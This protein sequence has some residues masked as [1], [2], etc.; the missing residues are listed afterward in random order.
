MADFDTPASKVRIE[1]TPGQV[2]RRVDERDIAEMLH[3][4]LGKLLGK[5][6]LRR[7]GEGKT[8]DETVDEAIQGA[9]KKP[10]DF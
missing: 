4:S 2:P 9:P 8:I 1:R 7:G 10:E 6:Q 3:D 5:K